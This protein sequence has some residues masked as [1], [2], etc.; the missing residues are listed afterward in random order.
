[1]A[2]RTVAA[3]RQRQRAAAVRSIVYIRVST[4]EQV[5]S[6]LGLE[7]QE[8]RCRAYATSRGYDVVWVFSDPG[9]SG[10][11]APDDRV[12]MAAALTRLDR[13]DADTLIAASLTRLGRSTRDVLDLADRA[14]ACGWDLV[15]LD[16]S[17]DTSTPTGRFALTMLAA[18]AQLERDQI[19][20]RTKA[21]LAALKARGVKL[22]R[23]VSPRTLTAG[24][25]ADGLRRDGLT[26]RQI[27]VMLT[28]ES[29]PTADGLD[30]HPTSAQRA[31][32]QYL[33]QQEGHSS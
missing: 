20:E 28:E 4:D 18:V 16:L 14:Q 19:S 1:M 5:G 2:K 25:R 17:L 26:W 15:M 7:A 23:P 10:T 8:D 31:H 32:Q 29:Y 21:A 22:G 6:G 30:W 33:T 13:G 27:A 12:G 9:V 3:A 11:I 24:R